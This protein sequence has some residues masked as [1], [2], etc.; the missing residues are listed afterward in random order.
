MLLIEEAL[1]DERGVDEAIL[2]TLE[3][4]TLETTELLEDELGARELLD[5]ETGAT[6]LPIDELEEVVAVPSLTKVAILFGSTNT[7]T[8]LL[9]T[10]D[11]PP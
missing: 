8:A 10:F 7:L 3:R 5:D 11:V 4:I 6:E 1:L 2:D 9:V